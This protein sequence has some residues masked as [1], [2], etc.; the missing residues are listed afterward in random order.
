MYFRGF[1]WP[2]NSF[3][4]SQLGKTCI[5]ISIKVRL[6]ALVSGKQDTSRLFHYQ[7][8]REDGEKKKHRDYKKKHAYPSHVYIYLELQICMHRRQSIIS[9]YLAPQDAKHVDIS[10]EER[11]IEHC[12]LDNG[13]GHRFAAGNM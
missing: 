12:G 13:N 9:C 2:F 3:P 6:W 1:F 7:K 11:G 5:E 10:A 8:G 4:N